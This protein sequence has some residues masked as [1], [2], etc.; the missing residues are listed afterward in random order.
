M[1]RVVSRFGRV[2]GVTVT[3]VVVA[4]GAAACDSAT[5]PTPAGGPATRVT[6]VSGNDQIAVV[7]Q[8]LSRPLVARA[9]DALGNPVAGAPVTFTVITGGGSID[10]DTV[11][12]DS[13]GVATAGTWT[14]GAEAGLQEVKAASGTAQVTFRAFAMPPPLGLQ[15]Q[16]AFVSLADS[17][18]DIAVVN[19][20]GSGFKRMK[21]PGMD[22]QPAW[23]PDGSRIA[24][25]S[26]GGDGGPSQ[27]H[28]MSADGT[29]VSRLTDGWDPAWSPDG[30][31]IAFTSLRDGNFQIAALSTANGAVTVLTAD[32]WGE[33][34]PTWSPDGRQ[35]AFVS[36][37]V[38]PAYVFDIYTMNADGTGQT[39]RTNGFD[40]WPKF[41][42][43]LQPAWSPDGS[44]IAFVLGELIGATA[45]MRFSVALMS[46]DGVF[47]R[48][49]AW[50]GDIAWEELL[51]PGSLTWSPD[52]RIIAYSFVDPSRVRSVKYV[53]LDGTLE[54]TLVSNAHSPSWR[55]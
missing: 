54:G 1:S 11:V 6:H 50:A 47:L 25:V 53:F 22:L 12:T 2:A 18:V 35:L 52:G 31:A 32:P 30:S 14:L 5:T 55:R 7:G 39:R 19:A 45:V 42:Y 37:Y 10:D 3:V 41:K 21:R 27:I 33:G 9:A 38:A 28:V 23:S 29:N 43:Y 40:M 49:L 8:S 51:D 26:D 13:E 20:D 4:M 17:S 15:G 36:E 44:K 46:A 16:I 34:Q 24:F 48:R